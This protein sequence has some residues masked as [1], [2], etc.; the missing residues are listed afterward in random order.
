[1]T[2]TNPDGTGDKND[3]NN[4]IKEFKEMMKERVKSTK[5]PLKFDEKFYDPILSGKKRMTFRRDAHRNI[6]DCFTING[7]YYQITEKIPTTLEDFITEYYREDG[8]ESVDQARKYFMNLYFSN[9]DGCKNYPGIKMDTSIRN[10][11][12]C[13]GDNCDFREVDGVIFKFE[14]ILR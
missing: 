2:I 8:F 1:M 14:E 6:W 4:S 12:E 13:Y 7:H 5:N 11:R 9:P 3:E 10:Y